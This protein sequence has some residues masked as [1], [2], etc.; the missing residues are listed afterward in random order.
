MA[1]WSAS[2]YALSIATAPFVRSGTLL[3]WGALLSDAQSSKQY[4]DEAL[5]PDVL[6]TRQFVGLYAAGLYEPCSIWTRIASVVA[7]RLFGSV[8][9]GSALGVVCVSWAGPQPGPR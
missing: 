9:I 8:S 4:A 1:L 5:H 6:P 7:P 2:K 3:T